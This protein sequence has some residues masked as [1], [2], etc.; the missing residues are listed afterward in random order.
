ML[1]AIDEKEPTFR[2]VGVKKSVAGQLRR[3]N[4]TSL[5]A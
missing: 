2:V 4:I 1:G 5:Q 3:A